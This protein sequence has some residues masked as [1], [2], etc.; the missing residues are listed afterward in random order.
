[1]FRKFKDKI[2]S[3][4][5]KK[6]EN[7]KYDV[8]ISGSGPAGLM[9]AYEFMTRGYNVLIIDQHA[10]SIRPQLVFL[11][12][13][14]KQYLETIIASDPT[15][16]ANEQ[17]RIFLNK[18]KTDREHYNI[19]DIERVIKRRLEN[20]KN[21]QFLNRAHISKIDMEKGIVEVESKSTEQQSFEFTYLI[22]ADGA[23][24][25]AADLLKDQHYDTGSHPVTAHERIH[26][27]T[28]YFTITPASKKVFNLPRTFIGTKFIDEDRYVY[29]YLEKSSYTKSKG[30]KIKASLTMTLPKEV[31]EKW[32]KDLKNPDLSESTKLLIQ[33]EIES[34]VNKHFV[35]ES[36]IIFTRSK[37]YTQAKDQLK[38]QLFKTKL[39]EADQAAILVNNRIF[40]R[41]GDSLRNPDFYAGHGIKLATKASIKLVQEIDSKSKEKAVIGYREFYR[42]LSENALSDTT[43]CKKQIE[44]DLG[45][46]YKSQLMD[47][48][49]N[50]EMKTVESLLQNPQFNPNQTLP[51]NEV[52]SFHTMVLMNNVDAL[53]IFLN[54]SNPDPNQTDNDGNT[55]LHYLVLHGR[56]IK[57]EM[58]QTLL[59]HQKVN[60]HLKNYENL[61]A[62]EIAINKKNYPI[63]DEFRR[64]ILREIKGQLFELNKSMNEASDLPR[65][66]TKSLLKMASLIDQFNEKKMEL[67]FVYKE[68]MQIGKDIA[69]N[70]SGVPTLFNNLNREDN[71]RRLIR[72][73]F[74][75]FGPNGVYV[76]YIPVTPF[77]NTVT[78]RM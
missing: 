37:K 35:S 68:I 65:L 75:K 19:K 63:V 24:H 25:A 29:F 23:K 44:R 69:S 22:G 7:T 5:A 33:A 67:D 1:M 38:M 36:K 11:Y 31:Y 8:I 43:S 47:A 9:T 14:T 59:S 54:D 78:I 20:K 40:A 72:E 26:H 71:N 32:E 61:T 13:E 58:I 76:A 45:R 64:K 21:C 70:L 28:T 50:N 74:E 42:E 77:E 62:M 60:I 39:F 6:S 15:S 27:I 41:V 34:I 56:N 57:T 73:F 10:E 2:F 49:D 46:Y 51:P 55:P 53:N 12:S 18:M 17:D 16:G 3:S 4:T 30:K 52:T 66:I 48:I